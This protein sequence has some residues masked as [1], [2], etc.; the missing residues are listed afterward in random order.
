MYCNV[1]FNLSVV[2]NSVIGILDLQMREH[3][4]KGIKVFFFSQSYIIVSNNK[5]NGRFLLNVYY[6]I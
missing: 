3:R 6:V 4:L 1:P 5:S 2:L